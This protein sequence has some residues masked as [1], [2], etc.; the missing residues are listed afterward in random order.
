MN[1]SEGGIRIE[2]RNQYEE[3]IMKSNEELEKMGGNKNREESKAN[4]HQP[5]RKAEWT[6]SEL[7][8]LYQLYKKKGTKWK[9]LEKHFPGRTVS[10]VKN[11]FYCELKKA[12]TRAKL[13]DPVAF[14]DDFI[15]SKSN[16][17]QFVDVAFTQGH[18]LSSKKGRKTINDK[19]IARKGKRIFAKHTEPEVQAEERI[20]VSPTILPVYP[21]PTQLTYL[22]QIVP[23]AYSK[24]NTEGYNM[25]A[26][27]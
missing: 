13:E 10:D 5:Q 17:L 20:A 11:K 18:L 15:P 6:Q 22:M 7:Q 2:G 19:K 24:I 12:A 8:V 21:Y 9:E 25:F 1:E 4:S 23:L 16:L 14:N 3:V 26:T 27:S